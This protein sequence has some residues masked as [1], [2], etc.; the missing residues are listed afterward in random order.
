MKEENLEALCPNMDILIAGLDVCH[1]LEWK[2][3]T[4][5]NTEE[6]ADIYNK[7]ILNMSMFLTERRICWVEKFDPDAM[8]GLKTLG[9]IVRLEQEQIK[10]K[11]LKELAWKYSDKFLWKEF[12]EII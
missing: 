8:M 6:T 7:S 11:S 10:H 4:V 3:S 2:G 5:W 9:S 1:V 12:N